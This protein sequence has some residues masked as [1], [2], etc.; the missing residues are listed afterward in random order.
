MG[1]RATLALPLLA[2]LASCAAPSIRDQALDR[3]P[4]GS[5]VIKAVFNRQGTAVAYIA[6]TEDGVFARRGPWKSRRLD[7]I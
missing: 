7:A 4:E 6:Q 3:V 1:I 2:F 5:T